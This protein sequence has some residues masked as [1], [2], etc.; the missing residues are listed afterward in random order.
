MPIVSPD[1]AFGR[2]I[3]FLRDRKRSYYLVFRS[4]AGREV[5][6]DLARFCRADRSTFHEDP[7]VAAALDG[8]REVF[9]RIQQHLNLSP[10]ELF[11]FYGGKY[12]ITND[13]AEQ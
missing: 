1:S 4:P 6:K 12:P 2:A 9:L 3:L 7:R 8:R 10:E 13:E 5:L 11:E